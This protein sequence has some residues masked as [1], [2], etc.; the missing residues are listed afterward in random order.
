[1]RFQVSAE[2]VGELDGSFRYV[3]LTKPVRLKQ[4]VSY[5]LLMPT[6]VADGD[7]FRDSASFDGLS[8]LVHPDVVV[9]RSMLIRNEDVQMP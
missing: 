8:P 5:I 1:M 3:R 7:H 9:R 6:E 2:H 4:D